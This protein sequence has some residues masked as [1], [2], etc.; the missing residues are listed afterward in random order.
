V[1]ELSMGFWKKAL[2]VGGVITVALFVVWSL[3][4]D[5]IE[6]ISPLPAHYSLI[7]L[8]MIIMFVFLIVGKVIDNKHKE[9]M[10]MHEN[11]KK[12]ETEE[13]ERNK[14]TAKTDKDYSGITQVIK[15]GTGEQNGES[16]GKN[17]PISQ[18][19]KGK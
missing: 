3:Y 14:Q 10:K 16:Y 4:K 6:K 12:L 18:T 8:G 13:L 7:I 15:G 9:T 5:A 2:G 19:I 11:Q 17:S 1:S